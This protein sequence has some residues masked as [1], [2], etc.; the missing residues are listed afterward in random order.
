MTDDVIPIER[1]KFDFSEDSAAEE[2]REL[3][4]E[5]KRNLGFMIDVVQ[6]G[7]WV[8]GNFKWRKDIGNG[9]IQIKADDEN[10]KNTGRAFMAVKFEDCVYLLH[11][12]KKLQQ[13]TPKENVEIAQKRYKRLKERLGK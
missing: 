4:D 11:S 7:E 1:K 5:M 12:F 9:V 8:E 13:K 10:G 6:K 3:S 2:I